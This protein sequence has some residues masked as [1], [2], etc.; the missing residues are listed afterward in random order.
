MDYINFA[1]IAVVIE[2]TL[3]TELSEKRLAHS[4]STARTASAL[5]IRFGLDANQGYLAGLSHDMARELPFS[6]QEEIYNEHSSC[7]GSLASRASLESL[8][9]DEVFYRKMLHGPA[10]ACILC[11]RYG[12]REPDILEAVALHSTADEDMSALARI[13][14]IA[15]KLEPTRKRPEDADMVL[16]TFNLDA[17]FAYTVR[18]V[19]RWFEESGKPL[20]PYTQSL[21]R[22][23]CAS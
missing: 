5:C 22:R 3:R 15:D 11:S 21:F 12:I 10:A 23:M 18:C 19:V 2:K 8:R 7:L 1:E 17:L 13:I 16:K 20:S 4:L 14:Y 9:E 6:Q